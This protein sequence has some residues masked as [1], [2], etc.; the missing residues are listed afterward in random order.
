MVPE[1][2]LTDEE[3]WSKDCPDQLR[4]SHIPE[5]LCEPVVVRWAF[6]CLPFTR[7]A[8][9]WLICMLGCT[10]VFTLVAEEEELDML[11][12]RCSILIIPWSLLFLWSGCCSFNCWF[13]FGEGSSMT[14]LVVSGPGPLIDCCADCLSQSL[15]LAWFPMWR[16]AAQSLC[17]AW[18]PMCRFAAG[19]DDKDDDD[20]DL[21]IMPLQLYLGFHG[22]QFEVSM[23]VI[24][25]SG[26]LQSLFVTICLVMNM[27]QPRRALHNPFN[28]A[29]PNNAEHKPICCCWRCF[30]L[31]SYL[32]RADDGPWCFLRRRVGGEG[33]TSW[34]S[35]SSSG[36][37]WVVAAAAWVRLLKQAFV[38]RASPLG[39][40]ILNLCRSEQVERELSLCSVAS[41]ATN[42]A[43]FFTN[44]LAISISITTSWTS[45][46]A[47]D[48]FLHAP[49]SSIKEEWWWLGSSCSSS[50]DVA[51]IFFFPLASFSRSYLV[52]LMLLRGRLRRCRNDP[53]MVHCISSRLATTWSSCSK[54]T[55]PYPFASFFSCVLHLSECNSLTILSAML[56][57]L[58]ETQHAEIKN[59][60]LISGDCKKDCG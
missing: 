1:V 46:A 54:L 18:S 25:A 29:P 51:S 28:G 21:G 40:R 57:H 11:W 12:E 58:L 36:L 44:R 30:S 43:S 3:R 5:V 23:C 22:L 38:A 42:V 4:R 17:P 13:I 26:T 7:S 37:S 41:A 56:L 27:V 49:G 35:F 19:N 47:G 48:Q 31:W 2:V 24:V 34:T 16:F 10:E 9:T 15:C 52:R 8:T 39:N 60:M 6:F 45:L 53:A 20:D 33:E 55:H 32:S 50:H 59:F 14:N